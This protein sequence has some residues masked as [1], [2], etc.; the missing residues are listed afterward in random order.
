MSIKLR[1]ALLL[2]S[3]LLGLLLA[4]GWLRHVAQV[5][6]E[7]LLATLRVLHL[8]H[9][10]P[11]IERAV[12][13]DGRQA[14][15]FLAFGVM[16]IAAV[17]LALQVWVLR[18]LGQIGRSLAGN[19]PQLARDVGREP[20]E[21]GEVARLVVTAFTQ[22]EALRHEVAERARAQSA[23]ERSEAALR[24]NLEVRARLGRDLHDGVIQSLYAAGMGLAGVRA[25][26]R[27]EQSE[28]MDRLDQTRAALNETIHDVRNYI[29]GLEPEALKL[30]SFS[31]AVAALLEAMRG[32]RAFQSTVEID[33][34][35][36]AALS[37]S[38]RVHALQITREA[39]SNALRHG[40]ATHLHVA[41]RLRAG[42]A[43]VEV[44]D[45]GRGFDSSA[46]PPTGHGLSNF[47]QRAREL[48][49]DLILHSAAGR[50]TTV[51]LVFSHPSS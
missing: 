21:L 33:D 5:E 48:G 49:A 27:P 47:A 23:L 9:E 2:G 51:K 6:R 18:P 4:L 3:L 26:L 46:P 44:N 38:Q 11:E 24:D 42:F 29:V 15:V 43:E 30:P 28:A 37:L 19:D 40:A 41:L 50:G 32:I 22:K 8:E 45:N 10:A 14:Q 17:A 34:A 20:N 16:L 36:A 31:Q 7:S 13:A 39:V 12:Q 25:A 1:L 35:L